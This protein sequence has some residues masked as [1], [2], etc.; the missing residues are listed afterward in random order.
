MLFTLADFNRFSALSREIVAG[1][2]AASLSA[3]LSHRIASLP[4]RL[5]RGVYVGGT[6]E[7]ARVWTRREETSLSG[8]RPAGGIYAGADTVLG[9]IYAGVGVGYGGDELI[10][11]PRPTVL[12]AEGRDSVPAPSVSGLLNVDAVH[13]AT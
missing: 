4:T 13:S 2:R 1:E 7:L 6:F 10:R 12:K 9:P 8:L 11:L 3:S 5:G